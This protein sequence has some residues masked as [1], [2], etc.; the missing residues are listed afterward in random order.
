[1]RAASRVKTGRKQWVLTKR[2][3]YPTTTAGEETEVADS[4]EATRQHMQ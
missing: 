3:Q 4:D 2:N 1:M